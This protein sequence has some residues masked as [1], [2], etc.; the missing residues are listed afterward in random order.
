MFDVGGCLLLYQIKR[1]V[2]EIMLEHDLMTSQ[3]V[4]WLTHFCQIRSLSHVTSWQL[5]RTTDWDTADNI[6]TRCR[7][8]RSLNTTNCGSKPPPTT[9]NCGSSLL[10]PQQKCSEVDWWW[11]HQQVTC[12]VTHLLSK[13]TRPWQVDLYLIEICIQPINTLWPHGKICR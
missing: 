9:T 5:R 1:D 12:D 7:L 11:C 6:F 8:W 3:A 13:Q 10:R 4:Y 2:I